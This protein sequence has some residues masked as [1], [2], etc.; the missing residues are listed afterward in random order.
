MQI[1]LHLGAHLTDEDRLSRCLIKNR[2]L[3]A[4][5]GIA[6]P[7]P[8]RY[9]ELLRAATERLKGQ[10]AAS[11]ATEA[12]LDEIVA[13]DDARRVV[14]SSQDFLG[15]RPWAIRDGALY[16]RAGERLSQLRNLFPEH[17]VEAH[18][19]IRNPAT[20]VASLVQ[21][22]HEKA[23]NRLLELPDIGALRWSG[24]VTAMREACPD[25]PLTVWCDEDTPYLWHEALRAVS[26]HSPGTT[27]EHTYDWFSQV[28]TPQ[29]L[30]TMLRWLR[31]HPPATEDQR[32]RIISAFLDKFHDAE[33]V[34]VDLNLP[35]WTEDIVD[36]LTALYDEDVQRIA[37]MEGVTLLT[38]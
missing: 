17:P 14:M 21:V 33:K 3:L 15:P 25:V 34:D 8:G 37:G 26:G 30:E 2:D 12:L 36:T 4:A 32:R 20:F 10:P 35:G 22:V 23:R 7:G 27:L 5:E 31:D 13:F 1:S 11:D 29:G 28:M 24:P 18:I 9:R 19:A 6:V 38:P 16:P